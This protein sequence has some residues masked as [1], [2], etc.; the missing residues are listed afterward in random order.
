MRFTIVTPSF[1]SAPWLKLCIPSVADQQGVTFEHIVQDSCS[2]DGTGEWLPLD[3]RVTAVF[4][5]DRGMYDAVNRGF[6]RARG[7]LLAYINCDEQYLPG[8]LKKVS[9]FFDRH[10]DV[11]VAFGDCV[12]VDGQGRYRCERRVLTP[13]RLHTQVSGNLS[14]LTAAAFLRRNVIHERGL[15][16]DD[17]LRVVGDVEWTLRLIR[18]GMRAAVLREFTSVFTDTGANM[19]MGANA[20]REKR[21]FVAS[22]PRWARICA[23]LI[24]AHF[25]LRHWQAGHYRCAP[26]D[27]AIYTADSPDRRKT[28]HVA[29]PTF[30]W[31]RLRPETHRQP[32]E[33]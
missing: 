22:V 28:F 24:V 15:F 32:L 5:K 1:N 2:T 14:F 7:E 27:Y 8:A 6:R 12:I 23:P 30:R 11:D 4:E 21:G 33:G 13:Q 17:K 16:F 9:D 3:P 10:P 25:R 29:N 20:A 19:S 18:S 26:H 31:I